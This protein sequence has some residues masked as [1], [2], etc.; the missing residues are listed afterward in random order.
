MMDAEGNEIYEGDIVYQRVFDCEE[1]DRKNM[2]TIV[3]PRGGFCIKPLIIDQERML[4]YI[5]PG[6]DE[7]G[8][9]KYRYEMP[10]PESISLYNILV[11]C[12]NV[13]EGGQ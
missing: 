6:V 5:E 2:Y 13:S 3:F 4:K 10:G 9:T 8:L 11:V 1:V 12:G 7:H